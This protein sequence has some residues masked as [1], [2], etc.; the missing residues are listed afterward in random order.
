MA[1]LWPVHRASRPT[2][3]RV[4]GHEALRDGGCSPA[5]LRVGTVALA[6]L[7]AVQAARSR[8]PA[9]DTRRLLTDQPW[10]EMP[11]AA[12]LASLETS[13]RSR[14]DA[15]IRRAAVAWPW[16]PEASTGTVSMYRPDD[17]VL[18]GISDRSVVVV[19]AGRSL[20]GT[21]TDAVAAPLRAALAQAIGKAADDD[22]LEPAGG[23]IAFRGQHD[24]SW[25]GYYDARRRAGF[26]GYASAD[27]SELD[28]WATLA[29][30]A[31]WWWPGEGLCVMAERPLAV[32]TEPLAGSH[33]GELRLHRADGPAIA[34]TDGFGADVL[35]GTPV[36]D[37]VLS[38]P[39]V[40][41]IRAEPNIEVWRSAIERLGWDAY[42]RDA[43]MTL[44][45]SCPDPGNPGAELGLYDDMP[46]KGWGAPG[47][48]LVVTN[49]TPEPD[50]HRRRYG[51]NVPGNLDN[52][53]DAAAWTYGLTGELY[54]TL[55]RRT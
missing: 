23:V 38:G 48:V 50:G 27:L 4:S 43:G 1:G 12:R 41:L 18:S 14:L 30:S 35:H 11:V 6:A 31:G 51:I 13:L 5:C 36:P 19:T 16:S 9:I 44:V 45:A 39:T 24:A 42:I 28:V 54:A 3:R 8:Y 10:R 53:I 47:R 40:D 55:A 25:I 21:L 49:G 33:R 15:R 46:G 7:H 17:A 20:H 29:K 32:H 2:G 34:F 22:Q 26:G 52:P 37:W